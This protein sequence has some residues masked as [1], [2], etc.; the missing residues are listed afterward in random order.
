MVSWNYYDRFDGIMDKYLPM[1][2]EGENKASQIVTAVNKLIY[3]WYNDGDV[4]DNTGYLQGWCNDL[5]SYANWLRVNTQMAGILDDIYECRTEDDY[6]AL[7]KVL[8]DDLLDE[9]YLERQALRPAT[10]T[11][12]QCDGPFR[13]EEPED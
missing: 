8:A 6:E 5:S 7:L 12:Y 11:I 10:G 1:S 9:E 2:G 4:F 3:K 13:F